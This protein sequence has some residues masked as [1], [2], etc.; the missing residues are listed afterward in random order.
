MSE[1]A[2]VKTSGLYVEVLSLQ[3]GTRRLVNEGVD[4]EKE[5][6][7]RVVSGAEIVIDS[8]FDVYGKDQPVAAAVLAWLAAYLYFIQLY[9]HRFVY[10]QLLGR[11]VVLVT[12]WHLP[13]APLSN[14]PPATARHKSSIETSTMSPPRRQLTQTACHYSRGSLW[15]SE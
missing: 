13:P 1:L 9:E 12:R 11:V 14:F 15:L 4:R 5:S 2:D 7:R 10:G 8:G 6:Q 3:N